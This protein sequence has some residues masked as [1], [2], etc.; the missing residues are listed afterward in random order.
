MVSHLQTLAR[1]GSK[2]AGAKKYLV[3]IF[4]LHWF[5]P[6]KRLFAP[7]SRSP[8]SKFFFNF[9]ILGGKYGKKWGQIWK[10]VLIKVVKLPHNFFCFSANFVF[11]A[12]FF[13]YWSYYLHR[14]RDSLSPIFGLF[15]DVRKNWRFLLLFLSHSSEKL[16]LFQGLQ[17]REFM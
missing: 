6:F 16:E 14:T 1:K 10:L 15:F 4:S 7:T 2:I 3:W 17:M 13:W 11:L 12:G 9:G 8:M 5:T